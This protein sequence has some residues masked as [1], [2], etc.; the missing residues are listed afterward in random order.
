MSRA[1]KPAFPSQPV[2]M[3]A[4]VGDTVMDQGG[5]T[6]LEHYAG[7]AMQGLV[8]A[9]DPQ[10]QSASPETIARWSVEVARA[11]IAELEKQTP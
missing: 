2:I 11:L 5:M 10:A 6:L 3:R 7:V 8:A 4:G 9:P 1:D